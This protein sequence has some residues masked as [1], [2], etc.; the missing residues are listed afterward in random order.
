MKNDLGEITDERTEEFVLMP[1]GRQGNTVIRVHCYEET[2]F[3]RLDGIIVT[4]RYGEGNINVGAST[5][6][7]LNNLEDGPHTIRLTAVDKA[8]RS[9]ETAV[10]IVVN[11][12]PLGGPG[13]AEEIIVAVVAIVIG[14][15][16]YLK[17]KK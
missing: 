2:T 13:Y 17:T 10:T 3:N 14:V 4:L 1:Y 16:V 8:Y 6:H 12:S 7:T 5:I 11:T 15:V 9:E